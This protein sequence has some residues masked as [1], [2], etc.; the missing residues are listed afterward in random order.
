[1]GE[2]IE[3][4]IG[5]SGEVQIPLHSEVSIHA[6]KAVVIENVRGN[7]S[8]YAGSDL[9]LRG[10]GTLLR[11]S[12]GGAVD[13]ECEQ[14]AGEH[15]KLEAGRD[16][17]CHIHDLTDV[18]VTVHDLGGHWGV[19]FGEGRRRLQIQCGGDLTLVTDQEF[20]VTSPDGVLGRIETPA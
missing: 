20:T 14:F 4:K 3:I 10:A 5:G 19:R 2:V 11:A 7:L 8:A 1:M 6:S 15:L 12:A 18:Q 13:L 9:S 16:V 17:H